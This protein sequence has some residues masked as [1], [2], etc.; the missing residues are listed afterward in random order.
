M[1]PLCIRMIGGSLARLFAA[2]LLQ[3]NGHDKDVPAA[4]H[5]TE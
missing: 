1:K 2:S 3:R 4:T 5:T